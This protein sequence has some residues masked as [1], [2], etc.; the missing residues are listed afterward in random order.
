MYDDIPADEEEAR[1]WFV[2][3]VQLTLEDKRNATRQDDQAER[4]SDTENRGA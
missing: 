4:S 1:S 2:H 3:E